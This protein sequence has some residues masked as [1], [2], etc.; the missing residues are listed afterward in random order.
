MLAGEMTIIKVA[1]V[2]NIPVATLR[3]RRTRGEGPRSFRLRRR[4]F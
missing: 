2:D 1:A 4:V 3:Y